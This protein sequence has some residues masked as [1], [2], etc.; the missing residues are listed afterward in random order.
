MSK[1]EKKDS[2][3]YI[4]G[5]AVL[6]GVMMRG[7][8]AYATAVRDPEGNIQVE[9]RRLN[10]SRGMRIV[11]KI[12]LVRGVVSFVSSLVTGSKILMRSA[13]VY[14]DEG[15]PSRFE[16]WCESKLHINVMAA[17]SFIAT[18]LGI[19]LAVGLFI[20]LP[21]LLADL[22]V[23]SGTWLVKYSVGYNLI[24][25]CIRLIIFIL[26]IVAITAMKDIR[27]V[28]MYHGAEH[29]TITCFEKGMELTPENAK[30]C[31]RIHDRCGTTFLFLVMAVSIVVFSVVNWVCDEYLN[32]FRFGNVVNF[33]IQ[34]GIKILFL[35]LVAGI[36]YEVLKLLA[37]TQSKIFLPIKAPGFALQKLTTREP[38]EDM[39]EV[40]IAA[41]KK[42]YEMD[43]DEKIGETDFTVSK[44]VKKYTEELKVLFAENG[45]D[46]SDAEWLVS[47]KTGIARSELAGSD[48]ILVPSRVRKL[49][50]IAGER[51]TGRPLWYILGDTEFYGYKIKVDER[52]LIPRPE[53]ELMTEQVLRTAEQGDK[54]LDL[55]TGSGCIAIALA[56]K[57]AEKE[58]TV[59]ASDI[60]ADALALA[61]ENAKRNGAD[62]KFIESDLL[63]G[64]RGKFNIIVCNP[65]YIKSGD[66]AGLQ[67]EVQFE[68][69][70][71]LDGGEDGL[72]FYRRLAK[73][74]PRHLVKGG[75]LFME[76]GIGQ[77][78]EIVKLFK[79]FD[80]TMVSRDYNDVERFV[81]AVL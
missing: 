24:Q 21:I 35:P 59:T 79:K 28:F 33:L 12:P 63:E 32:F 62:I 36:S 19:V 2:R 45:I 67:K 51:L 81:R 6:E 47:V 68:P 9:S 42:V 37:K 27:R 14:G 18:L 78:Q 52:V 29:K 22:L 26:Y 15:E 13:E 39:L 30:M 48:K 50:K 72:D 69:K 1:K 75:T 56:K 65:P 77:A 38:S 73:E 17:V 16:K 7:K 10:L 76:C 40:A 41:F 53:T 34:F 66:I 20:V 61:Q 25:G 3:T 5:Q 23:S 4:G 43:A 57:G 55:C 58:L 54:V 74:T 80:Y 49:D 70:G 71:A 11:S 64:V 60:S 46:E 31:S 8:T 44:T